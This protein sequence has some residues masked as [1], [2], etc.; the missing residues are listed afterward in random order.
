VHITIT[1]RRRPRLADVSL[2]ILPPAADPDLP[3][4]CTVA[5]IMTTTC[6]MADYLYTKETRS[7]LGYD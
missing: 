4:R 3:R 6:C 7:M 5:A 1:A 2:A